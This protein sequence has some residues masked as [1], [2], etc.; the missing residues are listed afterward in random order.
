MD[1]DHLNK[2][3]QED[4]FPG[5]NRAFSDLTTFMEN[6]AVT[7][8]TGAGVSVPTFPVWTDL[9][10]GLI[11][12]A[13]AR[14]LVNNSDEIAYY[15]SQIETDPLELANALEDKF[16][17]NIFRSRF[18]KEFANS[19]GTC[20]KSHGLL[21]ELSL[22]G[23]VTL[24]YDD[25]HEV[26]YAVKGRKPNTGRS[27]DEATLTRWI[28][29]EVFDGIDPPI[30]HLHGDISDPVKMILTADDYNQ[31]YALA[32]PGTLIKQLWQS[33]RL[34][35]IGFGFADPFL[36]RVAEAALRSLATD[37]RHF[38]LIGR[39]QGQPV[40]SVERQSFARKYR[41]M[42]VFYEIR[43]NKDD[44]HTDH[45][46]LIVLLENLP[47]AGASTTER[48]GSRATANL[49]PEIEPKIASDQV[50][51][52]EFER[53]LFICPTWK[54]LY[55]EPRLKAEPRLMAEFKNNNEQ[56]LTYDLWLN[57]GDIIS[58]SKSYIISSRPEY[59]STT[60]AR[61][62]LFEFVSAGKSALL[63]NATLLGVVFGGQHL[64]RAAPNPHS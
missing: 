29:N 46:D 54:P 36:T 49:Q 7:G 64:H 60:L 44:A 58:S 57:F 16:T 19:N 38:A 23:I 17:K 34:L 15:K 45:S 43:K 63:R 25:G 31:F 26:A 32:L 53:D 20:T 22:R 4:L 3:L 42:P 40:S 52:Q 14:G 8:F 24:N 51:K 18:A 30:L 5:N 39:A 35:G 48:P 27:Q 12:D 13:V 10:S 55:V 9:L 2:I 62:M 56:D 61:R 59:G 47:K 11:D 50:A 41:L 6:G 1:A 33:S 28:Q 21:S 37:V